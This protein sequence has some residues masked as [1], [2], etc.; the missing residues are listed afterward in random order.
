MSVDEMV[1]NT[2]VLVLGGAETSATT[3]SGTT[4]LL[5]KNPFVMKTLQQEIRSSFK[6][7]EEIGMTRPSSNHSHNHLY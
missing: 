1:N 5:L 2:S 6:S 3:L 4:Y 7:S